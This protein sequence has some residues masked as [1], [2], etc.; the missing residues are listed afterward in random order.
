MRNLF[1]SLKTGRNIFAILFMI[2]DSLALFI[3]TN[4][5]EK[6]HQEMLKKRIASLHLF[7]AEKLL[8]L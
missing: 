8:L 2:F 6:N 3:I 5:I 1:L 4:T 7:I